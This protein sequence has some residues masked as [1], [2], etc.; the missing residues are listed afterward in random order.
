MGQKWT[1]DPPTHSLV[2]PEILDQEERIAQQRELISRLDATGHRDL[3]N[4]ARQFL[5]NMCDTLT[6]MR[7]E[8]R[9]AKI[10]RREQSF[11]PVS[12]DEAMERV[13]RDCPL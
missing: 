7:L 1:D 10:R 8:E 11:S 9:A 2:A 13:M 5:G 12:E 3:A 6:T 4:E